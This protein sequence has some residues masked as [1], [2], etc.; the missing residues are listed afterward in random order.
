[1]HPELCAFDKLVLV[2]E[3]STWLDY[4]RYVTEDC[5]GSEWMFRGQGRDSWRLSTSLERNGI[6]PYRGGTLNSTVQLERRLLSAFKR[7]AHHYLSNPPTAEDTAGWLALMQHHGAPTRLLDWTKSPYVALFFAIETLNTSSRGAVWAIDSEWLKT[8]ANKVLHDHNRQLPSEVSRFF[9]KDVDQIS[10]HLQSFVDTE[11]VVRPQMIAQVEPFQINERMVAQQGTFLFDL[12]STG[13]EATLYQMMKA[14]PSLQE[15]PVRKAVIDV[16]L[17]THLLKELLR[18][19][20]QW[21][22]LFPGLDGF[23]KSLAHRVDIYRD[24]FSTNIDVFD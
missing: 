4:Q 12:A 2:R 1:M 22:S 24:Q 13:F 8:T 5:G 11:L 10:S 6:F 17:R 15:R 21:A 18:M 23:A 16:S 7:R 14:A 20:V 9:P 19:N 3:I